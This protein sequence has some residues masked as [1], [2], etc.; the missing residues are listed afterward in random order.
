MPLTLSSSL[1]RRYLS[2]RL[3]AEVR[4]HAR[5]PGGLPSAE[6]RRKGA[7]HLR[8]R[9][10]REL[11]I[12]RALARGATELQRDGRPHFYPAAGLDCI[13][14]LLAGARDVVLLDVSYLRPAGGDAPAILEDDL[15]AFIRTLLPGATVRR[16]RTPAPSLHVRFTLGR[17]ERTLRF[18]RGSMR[19]EGLLHRLLPRGCSLVELREAHFWRGS[20]AL[21]RT[22]LAHLAPAALLLND[23]GLWR[24]ARLRTPRWLLQWGEVVASVDGSPLP[25]SRLSLQAVKDRPERGGPLVVRRA[26]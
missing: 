1:I 26:R 2:A 5:W 22:Q 16:T 21:L 12:L 7:T 9:L 6:R 23:W 15:R 24:S 25:Q 3:D 4:R 17:E 19:D 8:A 13:A 11:P 18:V 10:R 20:W 14:G